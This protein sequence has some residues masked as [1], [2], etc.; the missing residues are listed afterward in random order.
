MGKTFDT[1]L[2]SRLVSDIAGQEVE[3][4]W[5]HSREL[6]DG[7]IGAANCRM[8]MLD[9][10]LVK[11]SDPLLPEVVLHEMAHVL[12]HKRYNDKHLEISDDEKEK[13]AT[14]FAND[15]LLR[16]GAD[17]VW[18]ALTDNLD[19]ERQQ[20][21]RTEMTN[22]SNSKIFARNRVKPEPYQRDPNALFEYDREWLAKGNRGTPRAHGTQQDSQRAQALEAQ[23]RHEHSLAA[24]VTDPKLRDMIRNSA[25]G[26]TEAAQA[27]RGKP[28]DPK[29]SRYERRIEHGSVRR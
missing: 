12:L 16:L 3:M 22:F 29:Q 23:A 10:S 7:L 13:E 2:L 18:D 26:K 24:K 17:F 27:M 19:Y 9:E 20:R 8:I 5:C 28:V 11:R 21:A 6:P 14:L 25:T 15:M 1:A 4:V